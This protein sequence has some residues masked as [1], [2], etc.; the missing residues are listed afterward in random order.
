M[1]SPGV[2]PTA[3]FLAV[4][5]LTRECLALLADTSLSGW[6]VAPVLDDLV[7]RHGRPAVVVS[8][9]GTELTSNAILSWADQHRVGWHYIAPGKPQQT[10]YVESFNGRLAMSLWL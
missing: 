3:I 9:N 8:D 10:A 7:Q 2:V 5:N 4:V 1:A 6:R